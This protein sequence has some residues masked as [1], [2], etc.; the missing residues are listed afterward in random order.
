MIAAVLATRTA[1]LAQVNVIVSGGFSAAYRDLLP[2]LEK[3][4]GVKVNTASGASQGNGPNTIGA[5]LRRGVPADVVIMSRE[6]LDELIA[7]GR[8]DASHKIGPLCLYFRLISLDPHL[9]KGAASCHQKDR[10][11]V[12]EFTRVGEEFLRVFPSSRRE[13]RTVSH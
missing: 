6:G 7:E 4:A 11:V 10:S 8:I 1:S 12:R 3:A 13:E 2:E 9:A 5:Q